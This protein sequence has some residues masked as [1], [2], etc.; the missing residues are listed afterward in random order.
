MDIQGY[1]VDYWLSKMTKKQPLLVIYDPHKQYKVLLPLAEEKGVKVIDT[2]GDPLEPRLEACDYWANSLGY[3]DGAR[4]I[5]Y[6]GIERPS[7]RN[8][9]IFDP[10]SCF[11]KGGICFPVGP[12]DEY[13]NLCKAFIPTKKAEID[14]LVKQNTISFNNINALLDGASYPELEHITG[15]KSV[16]EMTVGLLA[17]RQTENLLWMQEWNRFAEVHFPGLDSSGTDLKGVQQKLWQYLLFSEFVLDLPIKLPAN[18]GS[19]PCAPKEDRELVND[20]CRKIRNS[21]DMREL[22]V[23]FANRIMDS[24]HLE[25]EF[26]S[27]KDLGKIVTF[28]F[29]N[30]V[31]YDRY[32]EL[33]TN[34]RYEEAALLLRKNKGDVWYQ[35]SKTVEAFWNLAE[36]VSELFGC[37]SKG[38]LSKGTLVDMIAWYSAQG[39]KADMAFRRF[40]TLLQQLDYTNNQIKT[41]TQL[42]NSNYA[43]FTERCVKEYQQYAEKNG[44]ASDVKIHRN[45]TVFKQVKNDLDAGKKVVMVMADAF[46]YEMGMEFANNISSSYEVSCT[47]SFAFIPTVT[48]FGMGALL[49][50]ADAKIE[51]KTVEGKLMPVFEGE[52]VATPEQRVDYIKAH[53]SKKV[54]DSQIDKFDSANVPDGTSLLI[55][56]SFAIDQS[57]ENNSVKGFQ[58]MDAEVKSFARLLEE[59]RSMGFDAVY[60]FADHGYMM[61]HAYLSGNNIPSPAGS[62][63][64]NERRC[65]AGNIN[66]STHTISFTPE[67]LGIKSDLYKFSFAQNF[68]LFKAGK[69]YFHEGLSLQENLVPVVK[70]KLSKDTQTA[71]FS[72]NLTYK[73]ATEGIVYIQRPFIEVN[74]NFDDLFGS[75]V[76]IKMVIKDAVGNV[77]AE[78]VESSFYNGTTKVITIPQNSMK[79]KLPIELREGFNGDF[80]VTALDAN[81][82]VTLGSL[83]LTAE[84]D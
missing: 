38:I 58:L 63:V 83:T 77:V 10:Y 11:A 2:T 3:K 47:P 7:G 51:L 22:Y 8:E 82:N 37:I 27:S 31:E 56:R 69:V 80:T 17:A 44:L 29:E 65:V 5:V 61:Q 52:V 76:Q 26:K 1:I 64:L 59:C 54:F 9:E 4:L 16:Q 66:N 24:L 46:R 71:K 42:V 35:S 41:L 19:V 62:V 79:V 75:D 39:Y 45:I 48:R 30:R 33:I 70:V 57:G 23:Q 55:I 74:L 53:I 68:G 14:E 40:H 34:A 25:D 67:Q 84:I 60:F 21:V 6:R 36:Q 72:L 20:I 15:G 18:L 78:P 43:D 12:N 81:T 50:D 73:G 13:I 49:P 32:I 28:S